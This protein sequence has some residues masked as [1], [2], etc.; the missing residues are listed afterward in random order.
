MGLGHGFLSF[1]P[2]LAIDHAGNA[3]AVFEDVRSIGDS[4]LGARRHPAGGSWGPTVP[5]NLV[6]S[7]RPSDLALAVDLDGN[8]TA[9]WTE[10]GGTGAGLY[11]NRYPGGG[12]WGTA[13]LISE[14]TTSAGAPRMAVDPQGN[15]TLL[16]TQQVVPLPAFGHSHIYASR[17]PANG[18]WSTP[19]LVSDGAG[20]TSS[21]AA[22]VDEVGVV[23]AVWVQ[24][25]GTRASIWSNR[26]E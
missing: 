13:V 11:A 23:T 16:W 17:S 15:V 4:V 25:D 8:I 20:S 21:L 1:G 22:V 10:Y 18:S 19:A 3:M 24:S 6:S 26:F 7:A 5:I 2:E 9:V 12:P 14:I